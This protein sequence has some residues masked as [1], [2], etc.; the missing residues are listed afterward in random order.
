[1]TDN[2]EVHE[3]QEPSLYERYLGHRVNDNSVPQNAHVGHAHSDGCMD[4]AAD[5][6]MAIAVM[7]AEIKISYA[8][9][10]CKVFFSEDTPESL[11]L[12]IILTGMMAID[13]GPQG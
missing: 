7:E 13:Q 5:P 1:M 2:Y 10:Q 11:I 9:E 12:N 6:D 3:P 8:I 4:C